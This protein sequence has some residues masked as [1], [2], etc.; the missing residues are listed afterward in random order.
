VKTTN[1][2]VVI[3]RHFFYRLKYVSLFVSIFNPLTLKFGENA[4]HRMLLLHTRRSSSTKK[5]ASLLKYAMAY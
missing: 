2:Y 5:S 1:L 3:V 4:H